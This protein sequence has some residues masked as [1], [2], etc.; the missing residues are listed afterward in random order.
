MRHTALLLSLSNICFLLAMTQN[1]QI[2]LIKMGA[3]MLLSQPQP[4]FANSATTWQAFLSANAKQL[5]SAARALFPKKKTLARSCST[6]C[7][8]ELLSL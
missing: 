5:S 3:A 1:F 4:E 7:L 2:F 8:L 6:L